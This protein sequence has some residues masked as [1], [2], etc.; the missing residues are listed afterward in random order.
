MTHVTHLVMSMTHT[1][2][3]VGSSTCPRS[4]ILVH[5]EY[6][7]PVDKIRFCVPKIL[8]LDWDRDSFAQK[9]LSS[10]GKFASKCIACVR[11]ECVVFE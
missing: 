10:V 8:V 6:T 3:Q 1:Q 2:H 4:S 7:C 5:G 11:N 9:S